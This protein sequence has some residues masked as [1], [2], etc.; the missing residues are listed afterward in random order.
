MQ[1]WGVVSRRGRWYVVGHDLDRDD[2]GVPAVPDR[3]RGRRHRPG[4]TRTRCPP[5]VDLRAG[6]HL[7][8][9]RPTREATLRVRQGAGH[10]LRRRAASVRPAGPSEPDHDELRLDYAD[11][12]ALAEDVAGYGPAVRVVEPPALADAVVA[13]LRAVLAR[14]GGH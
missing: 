6:G 1:P 9:A 4:R 14:E 8:R 2:P 10:G 11:T 7:R 12:Q 5:D 13:R 3:R